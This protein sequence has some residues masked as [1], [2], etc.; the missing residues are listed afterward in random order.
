[1]P[2]MLNLSPMRVASLMLLFVASMMPAAFAQSLHPRLLDPGST[3]ELSRVTANDNRTPAGTLTDGVLELNLDIVWA[4]WRIETQDGPGLRVVAIAESG[5]APT[6]PGPLVRV[7]TG[8]TIRARV[9]NTLTDST[10]TVFGLQSR[11][12][13]ERNSLVVEPGEVGSVTFEVGEPG[14]YLYR[15]QL[16]AEVRGIRRERDQLAGAFIIDPEGGSLPDRVFVINIWSHTSDTSVTSVGRLLALTINGNSWP[17]TERL[18]PAVGDTVR[19]RVVNASRRSHPM[20]LH[21]FFYDVTSRGGPFEDT[22]YQ[23]EDHRTVVTELMQGRSTMAMEWVP[24]RSGNWLFHCHLSFHVAP[25]I[26]LPGASEADHLPH[27]PHMAGLVL[28]IEV[29]PGPSDL[30][31]RGEP[32]HITLYAKEYGADSLYQY[33]FSLDPNFQP[34][35]LHL[36]APGPLLVLKQY[37]TTYV[38]VENHMSI[39]TG[40]HWHGLELDSWSD[41]VPGWSASEGRVSPVIQPGEEFTYK[42]SLMRPGTFIYHS[43]LDD[44]HQLS[45]GLYGALLVFAEDDTYDPATDHLYV[46]GWTTPEPSLFERDRVLNGRYKQPE[47][48]AVAGETHRI[49]IIN[50]APAGRIT[51]RMLKGETP[52]PIRAVAKDGADL[53]PNQQ[54]EVEVT[55]RFGVGEVADYT[56]TPTEPGTYELV[57]GYGPRR[58]WRQR[59]EVVASG[60]SK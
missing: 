17:F 45:G 60:E 54:T 1:M 53:P 19:W 52:V 42:L 48:L 16:G 3:S 7:E 29:E 20:H 22:V 49:R 58:R 40:V 13:E 4:D 37:Q 23:P 10:I 9:R 41:G 18:R 57:V 24:T 30:I 11:P 33:G 12:A 47:Q 56:F 51:A 5:Q 46:V 59:W 50:I 36:P 25:E 43:H 26:R 31:S 27:D 15:V 35:S 14:T 39:P 44:V 34:D 28:G 8:T 2:V 32:R 6:V 21:G 38:T 55:Q